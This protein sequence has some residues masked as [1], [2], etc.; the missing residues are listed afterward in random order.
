MKRVSALW[1][2]FAS[3]AL[4]CL[5]GCPGS[6]DNPDLFVGAAAGAG[7]GAAG[8]GQGAAGA[9]Q[10]AA[11]TGGAAALVAPACLTS[12]FALSCSG[13]GCHSGSTPAGGLDLFSPGVA[14]RL[15]G[16]DAT[17]AGV[18]MGAAVTCTPAKLIDTQ[19]PAASWL[20][21]KLQGQQGTCGL[22]MPL[23]GSPLGTADLQCVSDFIA[24]VSG[25]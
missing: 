11:G 20:E 5:T 19:N 14:S 25:T 21:L 17:F 22:A 12:L 2:V 8:A 18:V 24:Q 16:V 7:Q 10:G 3:A 1:T 6:L 4:L 9:G 23:G 15:V 13:A